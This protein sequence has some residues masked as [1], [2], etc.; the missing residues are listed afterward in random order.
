[1][2]T[3]ALVPTDLNIFLHMKHAHLHMLQSANQPGWKLGEINIFEIARFAI[4]YAY[5][6]MCYAR[7]A[8]CTMYIVNYDRFTTVVCYFLFCLLKTNILFIF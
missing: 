2:R 4:A 6:D 8:Y 5:V 1:M 7:S 3:T